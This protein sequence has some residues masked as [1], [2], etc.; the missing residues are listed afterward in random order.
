[1]HT[2]RYGGHHWLCWGGSTSPFT[3][4]PFTTLPLR[5]NHLCPSACWDT[6]TRCPI[7]CWDLWKHYLPATSFAGGK[8]ILSISVSF[9]TKLLFASFWSYSNLPAGYFWLRF[10][11]VC[12]LNDNDAAL[13]KGN[14]TT[15]R[16][17][18]TANWVINYWLY[19]SI[20]ANWSN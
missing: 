14:K 18:G 19:A 7:T 1:M 9:Q 16:G 10:S 12:V 3:T 13:I 4:S 20:K 6:H 5:H 11:I 2:T 15:K 17:S 8:R